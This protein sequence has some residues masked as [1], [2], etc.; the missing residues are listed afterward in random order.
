MKGLLKTILTISCDI[1]VE[2]VGKKRIEWF[3]GEQ[4]ECPTQ[5]SD[6]EIQIKETVQ[7]F[8]STVISVIWLHMAFPSLPEITN[9]STKY[10]YSGRS[11]LIR[12]V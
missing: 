9:I 12:V 1:Q 6:F 11:T 4:I 8:N 7:Q 10:L 3:P 5:V 2:P